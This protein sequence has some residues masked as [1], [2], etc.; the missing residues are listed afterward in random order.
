[1]SLQNDV[2]KVS[3]NLQ[4]TQHLF[5]DIGTDPIE[6]PSEEEFILVTSDVALQTNEI[7]LFFLKRPVG[8]AHPFQTF[9]EYQYEQELLEDQYSSRTQNKSVQAK[10]VKK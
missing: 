3:M 10:T 6:E 4:T 1:M 8:K 9:A 2:E 5:H 7:G